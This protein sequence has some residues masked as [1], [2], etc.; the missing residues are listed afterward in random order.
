MKRICSEKNDLVSNVANLKE[1]FEKR[2]S[3]EQLIKGQ[4]ARASQ[5]ASNNSHCVKSV[6]IRSYAV[7][8]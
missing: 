8:I 1:W 6:R 4:V 2:S 5:S 7:P 3:A